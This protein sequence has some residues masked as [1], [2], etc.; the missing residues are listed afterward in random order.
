M[1][2][3]K[4]WLEEWV[5]TGLSAQA[6]ADKLTMAGL[7]VDHVTPAAPAIDKLVVG[8]IVSIAPHPNANKLNICQV[9]IGK[10]SLLQIVCGASN[11]D[12]GILAPVALV[13]C[14]L[15]NGMK[16]SPVELRGIESK[17]MLCSASE[18]GLEEASEGLLILEQ[19]ARPGTNVVDLLGLDDVIIEVDLTPNRGDCLSVAGIA[20]E[21]A[22]LTG[23]KLRPKKWSKP[24]SRDSRQ[25]KVSVSAK[26][27]CP[28]YVGRA[29]ESIDADA[30]TPLW[31]HEKLRRSGVRSIHPVVD[32]TNYVMLELGQPM[33][34]FDLDKLKGPIAV[35]M[36]RAGETI[37]LLDGQSVKLK[38]K[39]LLIADKQGP[40]AL[41][42]IMGGATTAVDENT[43]NVFLESAYFSPE[44]IAGKA[45]E[46]GLHTDSSHRFERGVDPGL[47]ETAIEYA[48][49]LLL[50]ICGG[51]PGRVIKAQS[52]VDLPKRKKIL[53]RKARL[54][55]VLGVEISSTA[56]ERYLKRLGMNVVKRAGGWTVTPPSYRFDINIEVD[57]IEEVAR[58]YGY[59]NLPSNSFAATGRM[60]PVPDGVMTEQRARELLVD[61]DYQE[62][63]TYSFVD[64]SM[65]QV[66]YPS[67][68]APSL[69][70][71]ISEEMAVMRAGLWPG[72]ISTAIYNLNRQQKRIR[73]FEKGGRFSLS[74]GRY[75]EAEVIGGLV[76]GTALPV[77]WGAAER[78]A[79]FFDLKGDIECL[80]AAAGIGNKVSY[81][82]TENSALHP[83]K[84]AEIRLD[85]RKIGDFGEIHPT[86][87]SKF[88]FDRPV[89]LFEIEYSALSVQNVPIFTEI[90]RFPAIRRDLALV[91]DENI[92]AKALLDCA[93]Q[94]AGPLLADLE[95]FDEY[96]GEGIDSGRK[97]L[98]LGLTLQDSSRTLNEEAVES[99]VQKVIDTLRRELG[100]EPRK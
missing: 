40:V 93:R 99:V 33:H 59:E 16:I 74:G 73:I 78:E 13:G 88:D 8:K 4:K 76:A 53:L 17:G 57:L 86:L 25:V 7:E 21:L 14:V 92:P 36:S 39:S 96:R 11:A 37:E 1:Q 30:V 55:S 63:I 20:R 69:S 84:G 80:L 79:D 44:A 22:A 90:S 47:Q 97:S 65:Q 89:Y 52:A 28:R 54:D 19:S 3:S 87:R 71:P 100:A 26:K 50:G 98:G 15:P 72:L 56:I 23:K 41:A 10:K 29:I 77:Q 24:R 42:G 70:N 46:Y 66:I 95:L 67:A 94:A 6:I 58:V 38:E 64:P 83:G 45:R 5:S 68:K 75:A 27:Q 48:T 62:V 82:K 18:L 61:R 60:I 31:M 85:G 43:T 91:L 2:I 81:E 51:K 32:I 9:D 12:V 35:R 34:S 49:A